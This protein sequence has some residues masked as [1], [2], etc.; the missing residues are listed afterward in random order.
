VDCGQ[1]SPRRFGEGFAFREARKLP[2][3]NQWFANKED[4][5][6]K[7][8][9]KHICYVLYRPAACQVNPNRR[10]AQFHSHCE[11]RDVKTPRIA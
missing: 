2:S 8:G 1:K 7:R 6:D 5:D 3:P 10:N 9:A 4:D 11:N